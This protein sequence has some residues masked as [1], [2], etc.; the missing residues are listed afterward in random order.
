MDTTKT[1]NTTKKILVADDSEIVRDLLARTLRNNGYEVRECSDGEQVWNLMEQGGY[2]PD[3][4][5][6]DIN[7]PKCDGIELVTRLR[8]VDRF[9]N[10]AILMVTAQST[11]HVKEKA[12]LL[13][14]RAWILKPVVPEVVLSALQRILGA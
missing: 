2:Q 11:P 12:K 10:L 1:T 3:L 5:L 7:M 9:K 14:I 4:C 6:F 8:S 13:G